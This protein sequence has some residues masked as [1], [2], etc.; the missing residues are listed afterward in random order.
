MTLQTALLIP[1]AEKGAGAAPYLV[2]GL[3]LLI[4]LALLLAMLAFGKGREHS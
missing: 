3:A 4:L 1:L 2:G